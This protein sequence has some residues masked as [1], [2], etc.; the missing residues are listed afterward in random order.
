MS[1]LSFEVPCLSQLANTMWLVNMMHP[2]RFHSLVEDHHQKGPIGVSPLARHGTK[3]LL[4]ALLNVDTSSIQ[5]CHCGSVGLRLF[6]LA[7]RSH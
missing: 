4:Y 7:E 3:H 2:G 6:W 5:D 1:D